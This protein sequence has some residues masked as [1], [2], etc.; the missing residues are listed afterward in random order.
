MTA[1]S[2]MIIFNFSF[3]FSIGNSGFL[4]A[5]FSIIAKEFPDRVATMFATLETFF[6]IGLIVGPTVSVCPF[7][8]LMYV[9]PIEANH[10]KNYELPLC[11][12]TDSYP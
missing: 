6:G 1:P 8:Y 10:S 11:F 3:P 2:Y 4:T 9:D 5:S 7:L 12:S